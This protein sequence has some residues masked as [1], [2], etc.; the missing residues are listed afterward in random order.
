MLHNPLHKDTFSNIQL[1]FEAISSSYHYHLGEEIEPGLA[2]ASSEITIESNSPQAS[3]PL[4][5]TI[6]VLSSASLLLLGLV[7]H[8]PHSPAP[9]L[10]TRCR[11]STS[12]FSWGGR[13]K[14]NSKCGL[15]RAE[16]WQ[17]LTCSC[18][19][20]DDGSQTSHQV[21]EQLEK[22]CKELICFWQLKK[23]LRSD[24]VTFFPRFKSCPLFLLRFW[25]WQRRN[26][27]NT[28][29]HNLCPLETQVVPWSALPF[30]QNM[31][32]TCY[33]SQLL[34]NTAFSCLTFSPFVLGWGSGWLFGKSAVDVKASP[35]QHT[36]QAVQSSWTTATR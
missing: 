26:H 11:A 17:M 24:Q 2:K 28:A 6:P 7:L 5:S 29:E 10:W 35:N 23:I 22:Q 19:A 16:L 9:F 18:W 12:F 3:F 20:Q 15:S 1:K 27:S 31:S 13:P 32:Y 36:D 34:F 4:S 14:L 33:T 25:L 8:T 21:K 30:Q